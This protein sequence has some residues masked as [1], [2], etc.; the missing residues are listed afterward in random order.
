MSP[1]ILQMEKLGLSA[2]EPHGQ[3]HTARKGQT[4][5]LPLVP[6]RPPRALMGSP[7][8]APG[9]PSD[10]T[11]HVSSGNVNGDWKYG[12]QVKGQVETYQNFAYPREQSPPP[13]PQ[14]HSS[15]TSA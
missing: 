8:F 11:Q 14:P 9:L 5:A 7:L 6:G 13:P 2:P 1:N 10:S 4:W 12:E 3:R 15:C